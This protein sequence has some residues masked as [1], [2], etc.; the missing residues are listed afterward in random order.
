MKF[1]TGQEFSNLVTR[2]QLI[3]Q[4]ELILEGYLTKFYKET[5]NTWTVGYTPID[6]G[7]PIYLCI[8]LSYDTINLANPTFKEVLHK[9]FPQNAYVKYICVF[10]VDN[11]FSLIDKKWIP[12]NS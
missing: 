4:S 2:F 8:M 10:Q 7:F 11:N 5:N 1:I 9:C 6:S 3:A 12:Q